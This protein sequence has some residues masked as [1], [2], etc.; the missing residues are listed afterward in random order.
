MAERQ[1]VADALDQALRID[2]PE[3]LRAV[4]RLVFEDRTRDMGITLE[5]WNIR[6]QC[7][8]ERRSRVRAEMRKVG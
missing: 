5:E 6:S 7:R 2:D 3:L 1:G 4:E 8:S